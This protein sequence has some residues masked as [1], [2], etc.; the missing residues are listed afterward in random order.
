MRLTDFKVLCFGCY[1]T[2]I[3]RDAGV[4]TALR[5]LIANARINMS[6][7]EI[8]TAFDRHQSAIE[9]ASP[10][11]VFPKVLAQAHRSLARDWAVLCSDAEHVSFGTSVRQWPPFA[12][13]PATLQYLKRYFKLAV[14]TNSDPDSIAASARRLDARF[15]WVFTS[16]DIG[17]R[18]PDPRNFEYL[19]GRLGELGYAPGEVV[20]VASSLPRDLVPAT[21]LG[22][23]T[24]WITRRAE[25]TDTDR[26]Q[27]P[28]DAPFS[29]YYSSLADMVRVHQEELRA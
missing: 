16:Q 11:L 12:D 26:V 7:G 27:L 1:G 20:H 14:L 19:L 8:L 28:G 24:A 21:R 10:D 6:R 22:I 17:S 15:D 3:D 4:L 29:P 23:A 25:D 5:R 13:V 18:K 2:L 9:S